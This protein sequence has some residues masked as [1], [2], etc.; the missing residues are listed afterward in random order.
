M[1]HGREQGLWKPDG[2]LD[3]L[4]VSPAF[5]CGLLNPALANKNKGGVNGTFDDDG[6]EEVITDDRRR[7]KRTMNSEGNGIK[8][9]GIGDMIKIEPVPDLVYFGHAG[10]LPGGGGARGQCVYLSSLPQKLPV[11]TNKSKDES[12]Y[13]RMVCHGC[14][15]TMCC[16]LCCVV[17]CC[18]VL[19]VNMYVCAEPWAGCIACSP[20]SL[21]WALHEDTGGVHCLL[22]CFTAVGVARRHTP[23]HPHTHTYTH[24]HKLHQVMEFYSQVIEPLLN[25]P[26]SKKGK[27]AFVLGLMWLREELGTPGTA[28]VEDHLETLP[29]G[30]S[31]AM[32]SRQWLSSQMDQVSGPR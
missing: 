14:A 2:P 26:H 1:A 21:L 16:V 25:A 27:E 22:A 4:R 23:T 31:S 15:C 29:N 30:S 12:E 13:W 6:S 11:T 18:D 19:C 10:M 20:A 8:L 24:I 7:S 28:L 32:G 9:E 5:A 3:E 17:L